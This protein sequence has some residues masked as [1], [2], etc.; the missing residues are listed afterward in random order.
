MYRQT[1]FCV[2]LDRRHPHPLRFSATNTPP[3]P[4][5]L[6]ST[7]ALEASTQYFLLKWSVFGFI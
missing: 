6:K 5:P 4:Y 7:S 1:Y 3:Y 2:H